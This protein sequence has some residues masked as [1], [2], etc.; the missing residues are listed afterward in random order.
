MTNPTHEFIS[1][2]QTIYG[3]RFNYSRIQYVNDD[4][5]V[6]LVCH[7]HGIFEQTQ[8]DHLNGPGCTLC[9]D[10]AARELWHT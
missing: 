6:E 4:T 7:I 9:S 1:Q 5:D 2:S 10:F 3:T 8:R